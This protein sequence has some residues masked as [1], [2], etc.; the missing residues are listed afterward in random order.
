MAEGTNTVYFNVRFKSGEVINTSDKKKSFV[1]NDFTLKQVESVS[2]DAGKYYVIQY[3][4]GG[5]AY[6]NDAYMAV[7]NEYSYSNLFNIIPVVVYNQT[8]YKFYNVQYGHYVSFTYNW[9]SSTLSITTTEYN[10]GA[11]FTL[12]RNNNNLFSVENG[13]WYWSLDG[14]TIKSVKPGS[15]TSNTSNAKWQIY[16]VVPPNNQ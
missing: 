2:F 1:V 15:S 13:G 12:T 7:S 16:E 10:N 4:G 14:S 5:Y 6:D 3:Y 8:R 11:N 9:G